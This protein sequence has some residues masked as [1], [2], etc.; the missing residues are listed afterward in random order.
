MHEW[1]HHLLQSSIRSW[2]AEDVGSGDITSWTTI[3]NNH[4]SR[5]MIHV[6]EQGIIAGL[7]VAQAVF[8]EIDDN[9]VFHIEK[10]EG[11]LVNPGDIVAIV[12]GNTQSILIGERLSL[13]LLQRLS[14]IATRTKQYVD[15]VG[16]LP[17]RIVDTRKTTPGHRFLEK[18]AVRVG[19][20]HNHRFGL[21]DAAMIKDNHIKAAGSIEIAIRLA[22]EHIPHTMKIEVEVENLQQVEQAIAASADIIMLDNMSISD[23]KQAVQTIKQQKPHIVVEGS[24]SVTLE[25]IKQLAETG[26]DVLSIG[27]LTH[28]FHCLDISLDLHEKKEVNR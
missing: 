26:V 23:M 20:G 15:A 13:N 9:V 25:K 21:Y 4:Y 1:N 27:R 18:Y 5:A 11:S 17:T 12:E 19:G 8:A 24:G 3:A 22:R 14:G 16:D 10:V 6:K 28:S 2:L 7:T